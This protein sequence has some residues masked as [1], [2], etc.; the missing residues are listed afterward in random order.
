MSNLVYVSFLKKMIKT[1]FLY[2]ARNINILKNCIE[3]H[4]KKMLNCIELVKLTY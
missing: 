4:I 2:R 3:Q 1:Y